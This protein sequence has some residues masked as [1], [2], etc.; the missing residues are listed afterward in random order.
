MFSSG[1][2]VH[3]PTVRVST[4]PADPPSVVLEELP[5]HEVV[6][7]SEVSAPLLLL[8]LRHARAV[9]RAFETLSTD[10]L[11]RQHQVP[12]DAPWVLHTD[13]LHARSIARAGDRI[14]P[15]SASADRQLCAGVWL[16][17]NG[18][19][20]QVPRN[21]SL[22]LKPRMV[23]DVLVVGYGLLDQLDGEPNLVERARVGVEWTMR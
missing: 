10:Y 4:S 8:S 18:A 2:G 5:E 22:S 14:V 11:V 9:D 12:L 17:A 21:S 16:A 23:A 1:H 15:D 19:H 3:D 6:L 20:V 13:R 7:D